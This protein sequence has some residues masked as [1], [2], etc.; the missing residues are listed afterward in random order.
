M[1]S[2]HQARLA[3]SVEHQTLNRRVGVR[4]SFKLDLV[5]TMYS[6]KAYRQVC[7]CASLK[8]LLEETT[9]ILLLIEHGLWEEEKIR[10]TIN[11]RLFINDLS[12]TE[13]LWTTG[14]RVNKHRNISRT[15]FPYL[16]VIN[17]WKYAFNPFYFISFYIFFVIFRVN[18]LRFLSP[19][20]IDFTYFGM[21]YDSATV[22]LSMHQHLTILCLTKDRW[23][24]FSIRSEDWVLNAI[25]FFN[26]VS[27]LAQISF[28]LFKRGRGGGANNIYPLILSK[29]VILSIS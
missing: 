23:W 14:C 4:T 9:M 18:Y 5:N 20:P 16:S 24:R 8:V 27:I 26:G 1:D 12:I 3:Q 11:I 22:L 10:W 2:I 21:A 13:W 19:S 6:Y 29:D 7:V 17:V 28:Y 15:N 25:R